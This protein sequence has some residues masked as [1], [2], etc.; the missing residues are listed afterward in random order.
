MYK[1]CSLIIN[2]QIDFVPEKYINK[3]INVELNN[4]STI[5]QIEIPLK[6]PVKYI[7]PIDNKER[8]FIHDQDMLHL[9]L[10]MKIFK[11][12]T[13]SYVSKGD[14][15]KIDNIKFVIQ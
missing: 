6:Y 5:I 9:G 8:I 2:N 12:K 1:N 7:G 10:Y 14:I 3:I 11:I 13:Y 15:L 4:S